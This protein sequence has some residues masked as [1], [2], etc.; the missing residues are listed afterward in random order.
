MAARCWLA[1]TIFW[2]Q[3]VQ[4]AVIP[5]PELVLVP[6]GLLALQLV[7]SLQGCH[8]LLIVRLQLQGLLIRLLGLQEAAPCL[9]TRK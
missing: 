1:L 4:Q 9:S 2:W 8:K 6:I 3:L 7:R 5:P